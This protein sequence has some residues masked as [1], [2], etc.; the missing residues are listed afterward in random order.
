MAVKKR[1]RRNKKNNQAQRSKGTEA[2]ALLGK[3][4]TFNHLADPSRHSSTQDFIDSLVTASKAGYYD[5][6]NVASPKE[7]VEGLTK[8]FKS[9]FEMFCYANFASYLIDAGKIKPTKTFSINEFTRAVAEL[10]MELVHLDPTIEE[11]EFYP[12]VFDLG[13]DVL[14]ISG[15]LKDIL[16][17]IT[18]FSKEIDE[19]MEEIIKSAKSKSEDPE[20][21]TY[22]SMIYNY[23]MAMLTTAKQEILESQESVTQEEVK[24]ESV[25]V[26][27]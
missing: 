22:G 20:S 12:K 14:S 17:N 4:G 25:E 3:L 15:S 11:G 23:A 2:I 8:G 5:R 27:E 26:E 21:I 13:N 18:P 1:N 24:E 6:S 16:D 9:I 7:I 10:D 19:C